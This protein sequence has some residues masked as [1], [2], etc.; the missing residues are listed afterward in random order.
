MFQAELQ[1]GLKLIGEKVSDKTLDQVMQ[2]A[3]NDRDGLIN[4]EGEQFIPN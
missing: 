4:F 3:D 2:A 1:E